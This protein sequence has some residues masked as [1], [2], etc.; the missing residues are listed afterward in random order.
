MTSTRVSPPTG[1]PLAEKRERLSEILRGYGSLIVAYSG[2]VDSAFLAAAAHETLGDRAIAITAHSPSLAE[3][4]LTDAVELARANGWNH[5]VIVTDEINDPRYTV[6]DT[7]RCFF[8]K[9]ELYTHLIEIA[10]SEGW[11]E[12]ANGTNTDDLGDFRPGLKAASDFSVR[13]PLVEVGLT[14]AEIR[15][16]SQQMDLP[17]WDKPAQA[18]LA[19]RIPY[20]TM[21]TVEALNQIAKAERGLREAGFRQL[22]VRHHGDVARIE[23]PVEDLKLLIDEETRQIVVKKLREAGY[24]YITMDLAGFRSG[25][26]NEAIG[27]AAPPVTGGGSP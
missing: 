9:T 5:R 17:T 1:L 18:C 10:R 19:S 23:V 25:S 15:T 6:N 20:G 4:E 14:K 21:V 8:C 24:L 26:M 16:L 11:N 22:R 27:K 12:V 7:Q 2:G 3:D 13:S